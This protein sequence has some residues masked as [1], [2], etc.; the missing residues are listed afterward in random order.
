MTPFIYALALAILVSMPSLAQNIASPNVGPP[1]SSATGEKAGLPSQDDSS[2]Q[3][4][5]AAKPAEDKGHTTIIGC[6]S[7]PDKDGKY[8]LRS[9]SHRTGVEVFGS[10]GLKAASSSKVKLTGLWKP[11]DQPAEPGSTKKARKF[12]VTDLEVMAAKCE[13]P[14]EKTPISK[15]KQLKQQQKQEE[16]QQQQK[17]QQQQQNSANPAGSG[18]TSNPK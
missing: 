7:G 18:G 14:T 2:T 11:S 9:M 17:Q 3:A 1:S 4:G 6:L 12:E 13:V 10:D 15:E 16:Q 5:H 8:T